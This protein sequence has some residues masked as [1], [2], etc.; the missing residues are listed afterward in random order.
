MIPK[1][2]MAVSKLPARNIR[3][4]VPVTTD[5]ILNLHQSPLEFDFSSVT[6]FGVIKVPTPQPPIRRMVG[7]VIPTTG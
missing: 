1:K 3:S 4:T 6:I 2:F 7:M 5:F